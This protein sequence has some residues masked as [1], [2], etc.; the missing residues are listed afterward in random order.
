MCKPFGEWKMSIAAQ[1]M[2]SGRYPE[3]GAYKKAS[4]HGMDN[5]IMERNSM[6]R[7]GTTA[8]FL[9]TYSPKMEAPKEG[10]QLKILTDLQVCVAV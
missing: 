1:L 6:T 3:L 9:Y 2:A 5:F 10:P 4:K 8:W 7:G